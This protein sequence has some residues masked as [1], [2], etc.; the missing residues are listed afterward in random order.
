V[1]A[2]SLF[3]QRAVA[4]RPELR[5]GPDNASAVAETCARLDGLPLAIELAAGWV[6]VLAVPALAERLRSRLALL[7]RGPRDL[8]ARHQT[9]RATID[10]SY[11]LL[12]PGERD[13]FSALAVFSGGAALDAVEAVRGEEEVLDGLAALLDASLITRDEAD[14]PRYRMLETIREYAAQRLA[15]HPQRERIA[16]AHAEYFLALAARTRPRY[17][18]DYAEADLRRVQAD[19]D[20]LRAAAQW[21]FEHGRWQDAARL[22]DGLWRYPEA[23]GHVEEIGAWVQEVL[24]EGR[25]AGPERGNLLLMAG[26]LASLHGEHERSERELPAALEELGPEQPQA[27]ARCQY[28]LGW[29]AFS[30]G[31]AEVAAAWIGQTYAAAQDAG[32]LVQQGRTLNTLGCICAELGD[33]QAARSHLTRS[34]ELARRVG[35]EHD[36]AA[37]L[38][39]A[40]LFH[41]RL[42]ELAAAGA[43]ADQALP[44]ARRDGSA[45]LLLSALCMV[46]HLALAEGDP[47]AAEQSYREV[48]RAAARSQ[49]RAL[50]ASA[51]AGWPVPHWSAATGTGRRGCSARPSAQQAASTRWSAT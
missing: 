22:V 40:G 11:Q 17:G 30:A 50:T 29:A 44:L 5:L 4:L 3:L 9:L 42:G 41:L 32:D 20:N 35:D 38:I 16:D 19:F 26:D 51:W 34:I 18:R 43:A 13:L 7:R 6:K 8:P 2:V 36:V 31:R 14:E 28:L 45:Q 12:A 49:I 27:R 10:W 21:L 15:E 47:G 1:P 23:R 48:V 37:G 24:V 25:L 33:D 46:G 39:N